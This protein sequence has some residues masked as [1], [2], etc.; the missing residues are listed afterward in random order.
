MNKGVVVGLVLA[1]GTVALVIYLTQKQ[2]NSATQVSG[3]GLPQQQL[4]ARRYAQ[5]TNINPIAAGVP[6][7]AQLFNQVLPA[8]TETP[9]GTT[10][11]W[12]TGGGGSTVSGG[13]Q[14]PLF[15]QDTSDTTSTPIGDTTYFG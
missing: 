11:S 14:S 4:P 7:V 3:G 6:V 1:A 9:F 5:N 8:V 2:R 10:T 15:S 13:P 12:D